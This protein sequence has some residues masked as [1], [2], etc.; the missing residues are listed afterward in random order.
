[1]EVLLPVIMLLVLKFLKI[2]FIAFLCVFF[3]PTIWQSHKYWLPK[4][5]NFPLNPFPFIT[6]TGIPFRS[7]DTT[8][9]LT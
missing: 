3:P 1:M 4:S 8:G 7:Q 9:P 2:I 6:Q 5:H